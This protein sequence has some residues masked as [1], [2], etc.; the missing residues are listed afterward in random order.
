MSNECIFCKIVSGD[1]PCYKVFEDGDFLA[2]LDIAPRNPGQVLVVPKTHYRWVWD[3][4][5]IG[6]YFEVAQCIVVA[7]KKT[8]DTDFVV[9]LQVGD[10]VPHAHVVLV[11]RFADDGHGGFLDMH[12]VRDIPKEEM[13]SIAERISKNI[14]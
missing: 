2:F 1:I 7:L 12:L 11:P 5:Q 3:H 9:G 14:V 10:E 4:P 6:R 8:L 13:A